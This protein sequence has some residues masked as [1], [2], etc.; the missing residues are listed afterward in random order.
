MRSPLRSLSLMSLMVGG[1]VAGLFLINGP[2]AVQTLTVA[3]N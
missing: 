2:A 3:P 1:L